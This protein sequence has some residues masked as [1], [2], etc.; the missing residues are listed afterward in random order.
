MLISI[1][2][3]FARRGAIPGDK[4]GSCIETVFQVR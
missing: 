3:R 2:A 4:E 1:D